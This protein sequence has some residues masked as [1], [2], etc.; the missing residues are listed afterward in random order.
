MLFLAG[1]SA[2]R[3]F[4]PLQTGSRQAPS[5]GSLAR[6]ATNHEAEAEPPK[7]PPEEGFA[8]PRS[9]T[10][11]KSS[12]EQPQQPRIAAGIPELH[13]VKQIKGFRAK[14]QVQVLAMC[15]RERFVRCCPALFCGP[16][17]W[18]FRMAAASS[19]MRAN[20]EKSSSCRRRKRV[21]GVRRSSH[22][23]TVSDLDFLLIFQSGPTCHLR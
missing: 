19:F 21:L 16:W 15:E 7:Q 9:R 8:T 23:S 2:I 6:E 22:F 13:P 3:Q 12:S 18:K 5:H 1:L 11:Q 14:L 20:P 17:L 4:G 10:C